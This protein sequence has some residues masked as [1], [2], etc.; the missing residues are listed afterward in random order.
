M[1][2]LERRIGDKSLLHLIGKGLRA[3]FFGRWQAKANNPRNSPRCCCV[4]NSS[5]CFPSRYSWWL[6]RESHQACSHKDRQPLS[7]LRMMHWWVSARSRTQGDSWRFCQSV[8]LS[9]AWRFTQRKPRW[10]SSLFQGSDDL[11]INRMEPLIFLVSP[12]TGGGTLSDSWTIKMRTS[13]KKLWV[14]MKAVL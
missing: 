6:V 3:G 11:R 9:M 1:G 8:P 4:T 12:T 14:K 13:S 2:F 7:A 5:D 10:W